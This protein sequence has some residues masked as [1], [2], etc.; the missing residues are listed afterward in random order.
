MPNCLACWTGFA[1]GIMAR[2]FRMC[3]T[4]EKRPAARLVSAMNEI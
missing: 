2:S 3:E 4:F 1:L